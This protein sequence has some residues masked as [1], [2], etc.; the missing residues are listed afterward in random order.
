LVLASIGA[1]VA[2]PLFG[3]FAALVGTFSNSL[4]AFIFPT[5]FYL[6]L[7]WG[8]SSLVRKIL[9]VVI[10]I[11][12]LLGMGIGSAVVLSDIIKEL[13]HR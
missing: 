12:G 3:L 10:L 8:T 4:I 13:G 11:F 9:C 1:A 7:F 2:V 6:Q 5:L